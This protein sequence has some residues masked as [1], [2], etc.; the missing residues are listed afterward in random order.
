MQQEEL[1]FLTSN[2]TPR[3]P[4]KLNGQTVWRREETKKRNKIAEEAAQLDFFDDLFEQE[5]KSQD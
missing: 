5:P 3:I 2:V 1:P 4:H